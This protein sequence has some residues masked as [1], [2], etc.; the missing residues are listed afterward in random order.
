MERKTLELIHG[1]EDS[2]WYQGRTAV[3]TSILRRLHVRGEEGILD[4]GAGYG[5]MREPLSAFGPDVYAFEPDGPASVESRKRGY[6]KVFETADEALSRRYGLVGLFDVVEHIEDDRAFLSR[7]RSSVDEGGHVAITVP[8]YQW[9]WS[10]HD[11]NNHHFRRYT[12]RRLVTL[13]Q[14]VG[15]E[16]DYAGYWNAVLLLPAAILRVLGMTGESALSGRGFIDALF[17]AIIRAEAL[18][19]RFIPLPFGVSVIVVAHPRTTTGR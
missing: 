10:V 15:Y 12:K 4:F 8:A 18:F 5:A 1:A 6:T 3:I 11:V 17:L 7:L 9:L 2:W 16:I 14:D 19:A 13:L